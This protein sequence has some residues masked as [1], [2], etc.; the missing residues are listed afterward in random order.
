MRPLHVTERNKAEPETGDSSL[1]NL[2]NEDR[3]GEVLG[4]VN[5]SEDVLS[6]TKTRLI[7][8]HKGEAV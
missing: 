7:F 3:T 2:A 5:G 4:V 1:C 6:Q 8:R